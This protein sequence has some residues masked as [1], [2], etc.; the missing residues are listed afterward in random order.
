MRQGWRIKEGIYL[1]W[2][3]LNYPLLWIF[4]GFG[5]LQSKVTML[6]SCLKYPNT[7]NLIMQPCH[8]TLDGLVL[9]IVRKYS[10]YATVHASEKLEA[11][12]APKGS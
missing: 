5:V 2:Q 7:Y 12:L 9:K 8:I 10:I 3:M 11:F 1:A 6:H 4:R